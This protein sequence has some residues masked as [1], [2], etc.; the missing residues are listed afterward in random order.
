MYS[1]NC[2]YAW[3]HLISHLSRGFLEAYE[4]VSD[5][6]SIGSAVFAQCTQ[7]DPRTTYVRHPYSHGPHLPTA[8]RR[9][10]L[11]T[12]GVITALACGAWI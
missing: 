6:I 5:G 9:C 10:G 2:P 11:E 7:T 12:A 3:G 4:S 1:Q 8:C